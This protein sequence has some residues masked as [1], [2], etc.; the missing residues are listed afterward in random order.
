MTAETGVGHGHVDYLKVYLALLV[1]LGVSLAGPLVGL[2]WLTL[3]TA[4]GVAVVKALMV[5]AYFMHLNIERRWVWYLLLLMLGFMIVLFAG[6][7]PDVLQGEGQ[8]WVKSSG[9]VPGH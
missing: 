6:V 4:F 7:A 5:A 8:H 2:W 3:V 1:L 9:A